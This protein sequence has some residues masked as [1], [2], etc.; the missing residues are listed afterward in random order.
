MQLTNSLVAFTFDPQTGSLTQIE[1]LRTGTA[2][3][4][5]PSEG[6]LFRVGR[7]MMRIGAI[8]MATAICRARRRWR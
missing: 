2:Y 5:D 3:L 7:R 1:D 4:S 8:G 6:R